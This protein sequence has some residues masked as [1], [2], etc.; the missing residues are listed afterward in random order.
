VMRGPSAEDEET[1]ICFVCME[2]NAPSSRCACTDR[3]VHEECMMQWLKQ[4]GTNTCPVCTEPYPHVGFQIR[5]RTRPSCNCWGTL[6]GTVCFLGLF[7]CGTIQLWMYLDPAFVSVNLS[8]ASGL[9]MLAGGVIGL[10]VCVLFGVRFYR[11]NFKIF[12][13]ES[14]KTVVLQA[15]SGVEAV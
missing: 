11:A 7:T 4:H 12:E 2:P 15:V 13:R 3:Y 10:F 5:T 14:R 6:L 1:N 8:L 9:V